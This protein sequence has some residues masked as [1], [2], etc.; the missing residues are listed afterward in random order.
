VRPDTPPLSS[1]RRGAP[2]RR[3]RTGGL[4]AVALLAVAGSAGT[5]SYTV[6]WGDTLSE[7]AA[8]H[9]VSVGELAFANGITDP[10]HVVAGRT[11]SVPGQAA[12]APVPLRHEV[13]WGDTLSSIASRY[14]VSIHKLAAANGIADLHRVIAGRTLT[15]PGGDAPGAPPP[16]VA[17]HTVT[18]GETLSGIAARYGVSVRALAAANGIVDTSLVRIGARLSLPAP[19]TIPA[20]GSSLPR[21]LRASPSRL[22]L[23][24]LFE[25]W[26]AHHGVPADLLMAMAWVESGWQSA[27]TSPVGAMGVG[28]LMPDTVRWMR[29]LIGERLDPRDPSDNIRMA[30]RYMQWLLRR[31]NGDE[32]TAVAGYYQGLASVRHRGM[33]RMTRSY[34]D[35][36]AAVRARHF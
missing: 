30:A 26:A 16:P 13:A 23:I 4:A 22:A 3:R 14:A 27:A 6:R 29:R 7:V 9:H 17:R 25:V 31:T 28:Q 5:G 18:E 11:I 32:A 8:R 2:R 20:P 15:I 10:D 19:E 12:P 33:F 34:L 35:V 21:R 1:L 36:V 24:P